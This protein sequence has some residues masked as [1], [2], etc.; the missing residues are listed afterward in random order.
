MLVLPLILYDSG[1]RQGL[2][3]DGNLS[4]PAWNTQRSDQKFTGNPWTQSG[5]TYG[6]GSFTHHALDSFNIV[7]NTNSNSSIYR[8]GADNNWNRITT[9]MSNNSLSGNNYGHVMQHGIGLYHDHSGYTGTKMYSLG[10]DAYCDNANDHTA[11]NDSWYGG[12]SNAFCQG[13][14]GMNTSHE[15]FSIWVA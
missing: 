14:S 7:F 2:Y 6:A 1:G 11:D 5:N 3:T 9:T 10:Q 15:G 13:G 12:G 4:G 8:S